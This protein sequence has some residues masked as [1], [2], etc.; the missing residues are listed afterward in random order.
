MLIFVWTVD[1]NFEWMSSHRSVGLC[2]LREKR[3]LKWLYLY[4]FFLS[5][6]RIKFMGIKNAY[7]HFVS[8]RVFALWQLTARILCAIE[9]HRW[10]YFVVVLKYSQVYLCALFSFSKEKNSFSRLSPRCERNIFFWWHRWNCVEIL[11]I[12]HLIR[13]WPFHLIVIVS[14]VII[15]F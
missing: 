13:E 2:A 11:D 10:E 12:Y 3:T 5:L 9:V 15:T 4:L 6:S 7:V 14:T 8:K 1:N